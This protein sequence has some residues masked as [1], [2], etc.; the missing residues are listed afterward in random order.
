MFRLLLPG[1]GPL[2]PG[3]GFGFEAGLEADVRV[4]MDGDGDEDEDEA[5]GATETEI[6]EESRGLRRRGSKA[7]ESMTAI[8]L[9]V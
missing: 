8:F 5:A 7:A 9:T 1:S 2:A 4:G 3:V 6:D